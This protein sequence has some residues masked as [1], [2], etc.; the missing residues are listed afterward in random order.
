M[1]GSVLIDHTDKILVIGSDLTPDVVNHSFLNAHY[2]LVIHP[3]TFDVE[4]DEF[5]EMPVSIVLLCSEGR[6][7][8]EDPFKPP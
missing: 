2:I 5:V 7:D 6:A 1:T 4:G 3:S 8:F